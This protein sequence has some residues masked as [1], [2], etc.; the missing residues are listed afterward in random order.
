MTV[1]SDF[2]QMYMSMS[3][4]HVSNAQKGPEKNST[5]SHKAADEERLACK[6]DLALAAAALKEERRNRMR[7][8]NT[9]AVRPKSAGG[10]PDAE[11]GNDGDAA[12]RGANSTK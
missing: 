3:M 11:P 6:T 10:R 12:R 5:K 4:V 1:T 2:L 9:G 8:R 7:E